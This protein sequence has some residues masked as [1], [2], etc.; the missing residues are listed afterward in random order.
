MTSQD[1]SHTR[2]ESDI[3]SERGISRRSLLGIIGIGAGAVAVFVPAL[4]GAAVVNRNVGDIVGNPAV[5][6]A[7]PKLPKNLRVQTQRKPAKKR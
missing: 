2:S 5:S 4:S 6:P 7:K 1:Q 3:S